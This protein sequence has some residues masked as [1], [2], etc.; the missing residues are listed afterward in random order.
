[1]RT[2]A[3]SLPTTLQGVDQRGEH[4]DRRAVLVV[5]EDR[6]VEAGAQPTLDLEAAR[7]RDVLEVDAG[8][9]R[10][11]QLDRAHD[12]VDVLGVEADRE[13]VDAGEPLEQRRLALHHR[14]RGERAEVAQ[15]EHRGA[16]GDDGDGVALD[17]QP[18]GVLGV[19]G[20]R[21]ADPRDARRVDHRQVVAVADRHLG[22][23]LDLAA[24][25][26]QE[27]AVGDLADG[28]ALDAR[29]APRSA[30]SACSVSLA[31]QVTSMLQ[32]LVPGR[33]DVERGDDPAGLLDRV[34]SAG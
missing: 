12:L 15:P 30:C 3:S 20:D 19:L 13:R 25:V 33:R 34:R 10:G 18:A 2:S 23:D 14:Q 17:R 26:H 21:Q 8:E 32:P 1:M 27:G 24:E 28:H 31:A 29:R 9:D 7:R 11:D 4:D 16:V 22:L 6:D 5:V